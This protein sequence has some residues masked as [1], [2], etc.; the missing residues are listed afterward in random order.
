MT[1]KE[2]KIQKALGIEF[3]YCS[4]CKKDILKSLAYYYGDI[5]GDIHNNTCMCKNCVARLQK[6][7]IN[8]DGFHIEKKKEKH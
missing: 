2:I 6:I 7:S 8:W 5:H 1:K 4:I 3:V